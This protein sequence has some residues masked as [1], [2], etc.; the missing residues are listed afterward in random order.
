[1]TGLTV[2]ASLGYGHERDHHN[3][4]DSAAL[5]AARSL[6]QT[7]NASS[8][9]GRQGPAVTAANAVAALNGFASSTL[10]VQPIDFNGASTTWLAAQG[11][12]VTVTQSYRRFV[13]QAVGL[14]NNTVA[15][16]AQA[17]YGYPLGV[18]NVVPIQIAS[19]APQVGVTGAVDCMSPASGGSCSTNFTPFEPAPPC[20]TSSSDPNF[21]PCFLRA[22]QRGMSSSNPV[23]LNASYPSRNWSGTL[24]MP[25][26]STKAVW[27]LLQDRINTD[28]TA[29]SS[30]HS[31]DSPR[32][33]FATVGP[34]SSGNPT[35][36]IANFQCLF[37]NSVTA[38]TI[39][40]TYLDSC[41][42]TVAPGTGLSA[43]P[44]TGAVGNNARSSLVIRLIA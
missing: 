26:G 9:A 2:D 43:T 7:W 42:T 33:F 19:D 17:I 38:D 44:P 30:K 1:M 18:S 31:S 40:V 8:G 41:V 37:L 29:T 14:G 20:P 5:A 25:D 12:Q 22:V 23:K 32:V 39:T 24:S 28:P 36:A 27:Q 4:A 13:G 34:S 3:V 21:D 10:N 35:I 15:D 16:S 6:S 11:V